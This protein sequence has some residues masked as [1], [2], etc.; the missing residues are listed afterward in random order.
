MLAVSYE[1]CVAISPGGHG[2]DAPENQQDDDD[3]KN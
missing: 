1:M 3:D 2:S